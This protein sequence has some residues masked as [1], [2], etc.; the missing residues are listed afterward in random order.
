[1]TP[2]RRRPRVVAMTPQPHP[3]ASL[4]LSERTPRESRLRRAAT[5]AAR[6]EVEMSS[7]LSRCRA[8]RTSASGGRLEC[9]ARMSHRSTT[10][11]HLHAPRPHAHSLSLMLASFCRE[12]IRDKGKPSAA[13]CTT[14]FRP[15]TPPVAS[16]IRRTS[17]NRF[18]GVRGLKVGVPSDEKGEEDAIHR[19][20]WSQRSAIRTRRREDRQARRATRGARDPVAFV[21]HPAPP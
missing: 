3:G 21:R 15:R 12:R 16:G 2:R 6:V 19:A 18:E 20:G 11:N 17:R 5:N 4:P 8:P 13:P 1:M 9:A 7:L 14:S 10:T